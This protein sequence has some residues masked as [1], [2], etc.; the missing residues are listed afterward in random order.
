M[1]TTARRE[2]CPRFHAAIELIGR[3]W[4]GAIIVLLQ[5]SPARYAELRAAIPDITDRMLAERL[6]ELEAEGLVTR[7]VLP[8][9]PV[10]VR[11]SITGKGRALGRAMKAIATWAEKWVPAPASKPPPSA[12]APPAR[13]RPPRRG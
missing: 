11:Y 5:Q 7:A 12:A 6:R 10:R 4:A 13:G 8:D 1:K 3:R 9:P 2:L